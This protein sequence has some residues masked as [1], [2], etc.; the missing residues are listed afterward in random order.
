MTHIVDRILAACGALF[1]AA[2]LAALSA[3]AHVDSGGNYTT[4]GWMLMV[5]A[6]PV[7]FLGTVAPF[8]TVWR[9][10][11]LLFMI[12]GTV[13]FAGDVSY[14]TYAGESLFPMAAPTGGTLLI[15]AWIALALVLL[16]VS[17]GQR[18]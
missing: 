9:R 10:L 6:G 3:G 1:G 18:R 16:L 17:S 8:T 15:L 14:R 2:G 11:V 5:H 13:I 7:V 4:A 12:A